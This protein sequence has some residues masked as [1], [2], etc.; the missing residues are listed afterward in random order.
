LVRNDDAAL[1]K[2]ITEAMKYNLDTKL[3]KS[4]DWEGEIR[5]FITHLE[6]DLE[7]WIKLSFGQFSD[8]VGLLKKHNLDKERFAKEYVYKVDARFERGT[9]AKK[10]DCSWPYCD[11][12]EEDLFLEKDHIL[13]KSLFPNHTTFISNPEINMMW[14]CAFHN[15]MKTNSLE[16]GIAFAIGRQRKHFKTHL[17]E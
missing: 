9:L 1:F 14:L 17:Y 10:D 2:L 3:S 6:S 7:E 13:P 4:D 15:R 12:K 11:N 16:L 5:S 8:F